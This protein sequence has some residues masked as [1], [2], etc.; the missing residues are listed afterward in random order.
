[1]CTPFDYDDDRRR[2]ENGYANYYFYSNNKFYTTSRLIYIHF[3]TLVGF[4]IAYFSIITKSN[5]R[6]EGGTVSLSL[7]LFESPYYILYCTS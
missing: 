7:S 6:V 5:I 4:L 1:M 2:Y 3:Y